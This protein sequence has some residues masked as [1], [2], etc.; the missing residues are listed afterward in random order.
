VPWCAG[1]ISGCP[2]CVVAITEVREQLHAEALNV[3]ELVQVP[4]ALLI[5]VR[6]WCALGQMLS[7]RHTGRSF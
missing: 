2:W 5:P 4:G 1:V 6:M 7:L 3:N